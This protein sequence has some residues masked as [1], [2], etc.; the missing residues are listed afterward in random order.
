MEIG[1]TIKVVGRPE[2]ILKRLEKFLN[3]YMKSKVCIRH[4]RGPP[5]PII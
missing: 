1:E 2:M 3:E 5:R 4:K